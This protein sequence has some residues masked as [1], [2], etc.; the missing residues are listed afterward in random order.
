[1]MK[2]EA[3]YT[4]VN[5]TTARTA[6]TINSFSEY[7]EG[8]AT[9][10][11]KHY[12]DAIVNY[13]NELLEKH[14][15]DDADKL[16]KVQYYIDSYSKKV[17]AAID[18][19]NRIDAMC[20]S[21]MICGAGNFPTRRKEKQVAA[22]ENHYRDTAY[23]YNTDDSNYYFKKIRTTL[24]DSGIIRSDDKNAVQMIKNKIA[25]L[26][27]E[28]D[29][30]GNNKAEIRRLKGRLLQLAPEEQKKDIEITINGKEATFEN[31]VAI[32]N[33]SLPQKSRFSEDEERY[34]LNIPLCFSNGKRK[35][36]EYLSNEVNEDCTLLSTYGNREN[37]YKT[38][39]KPLNDNLKFMLIINKITGS[40]NKAVIYSILKD[41]LPK[42]E[43]EEKEEVT[44]ENLPFKTVKNN[45]L[46]RLQ[47]LFD[48]KPS[49]E[50]R[51]ILKSNGFRWSPNQKAWQRLLNDNAL[52]SLKRISE[53]IASIE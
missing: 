29:A 48:G 53:Q 2:F 20:P 6:K 9:A 1:M 35:Y 42:A 34:Y 46:M 47:L 50:I 15:T 19:S 49:E 30:Y 28:P 36:N 12:T 4:N 52:Y 51:T 7:K 33:E 32:F 11:Q 13:A 25:R 23:L 5:E 26:E 37:G 43:A 18:K 41:L 3:N 31:I 17:A 14:Q 39:W 24:T 10:E 38:I 8:T 40:G 45:D 22:M 44:A 16:E 21:V 27:S